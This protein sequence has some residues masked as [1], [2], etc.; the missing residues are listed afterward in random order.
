MW[1]EI[2]EDGIDKRE[3]AGLSETI[4]RIALTVKLKQDTIYQ[5][6]P[7]FAVVGH[8]TLVPHIIDD[9]QV[10]HPNDKVSVCN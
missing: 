3:R 1:M 7:L 9:D 2:F 5:R 6:W 8:V 10:T 4:D